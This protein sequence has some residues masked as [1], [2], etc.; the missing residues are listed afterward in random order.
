MIENLNFII[1]G[2]KKSRTMEKPAVKEGLPDICRNYFTVVDDV[3]V[4]KRKVF[5]RDFW[6][7][8]ETS[9]E[10]SFPPALIKTLKII[11]PREKL[12]LM[13]SYGDVSS[14]RIFA[15]HGIK[16]KRCTLSLYSTRSDLLIYNSSFELGNVCDSLFYNIDETCV[17]CGINLVRPFRPKTDETQ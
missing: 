4:L 11:T 7:F 12:D 14:F 15:F 3:P 16:C 5:F 10:W 13:L 2:K 8:C 9:S 1:L 17:D 6:T